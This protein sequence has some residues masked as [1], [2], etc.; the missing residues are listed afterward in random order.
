LANWLIC[1]LLTNSLLAFYLPY[2]LDVSASGGVP[3]GGAPFV[4]VAEE[5]ALVG[6]HYEDFNFS[7]EDVA[8]VV[9]EMPPGYVSVA[10]D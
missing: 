4:G 9:I 6:V 7:G 5:V 10:G 1:S 8:L 2:Q 3:G